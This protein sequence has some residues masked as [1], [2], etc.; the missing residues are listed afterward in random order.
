MKL[1]LRLLT[2][3]GMACGGAGTGHAHYGEPRAVSGAYSMEVTDE[4][5]APLRTFEHGGRTYVLGEQGQRYR[6]RVRNQ[7]GARVEAVISV[8]GR[9]ALDGKPARWDKRGYILDPWGEV[10]VDGFRLSLADVATFRFSD[11]RGSYAAKMGDA[12]NVGVI[13]VALFPERVYAPPPRPAVAK[14]RYRRSGGS[15]GAPTSPP[16]GRSADGTDFDDIGGLGKSGTSAGANADTMGPA[17]EESSAKRSASSSAAPRP[18]D[19]PGLGTA[20]GERRESRVSEV[21]FRR[22][23]PAHPDHL[24][25]IR[26][27]DRDGLL[28]LGIDVDGAHRVRSDA[29]LRET[30]RPFG[31]GYSAPPPGWTR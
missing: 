16:A 6:L 1:E 15:G 21:Q 18:E 5:G 12:R 26:Y 2:I 25:A 4:W 8:D 10:V 31:A 17:A 9:D 28:A 3:I 24:L 19:R 13:G 11:V 14:E 20:F 27:N 30:A 7:S 22:A 29:W 23:H